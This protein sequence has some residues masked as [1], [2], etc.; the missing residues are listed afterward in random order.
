MCK[1]L[2]NPATNQQIHNNMKKIA[3][4]LISMF[5]LSACNRES[6]PDGRSQ[7][8]DEKIQMQIDSLKKQQT[9]LEDSFEVMKD[10]WKK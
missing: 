2:K 6:S 7:I 9:A 5:A 3:L 8:R 1:I 4:I 10:R